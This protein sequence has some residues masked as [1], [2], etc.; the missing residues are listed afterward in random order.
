MKK[1]FLFFI[2]LIFT[3]LSTSAQNQQI[4][5]GKDYLHSNEV[6]LVGEKS[7]SATIQFDLNEL[8]LVEVATNYGSASKMSS[9]KAPI[10][11]DAGN[12]E[13]IYLP[14]ALVIPDVGAAELSITHGAY[15]EIENVEIAPSKGNLPRSVNP[16]TVPYVK[17]AVYEQNAFFPGNL[18]AIN[19]TF[20]M[21]DVR[22]A[23]I[24]AYPVQY[25][26]VTKVL[27]I[28]SEM[29]VT[30][31][32]TDQPGENEF[33]NQ[34]RNTTIDPTFSQMYNNMFINHSS[35]SRDY[36]T[37]EE[38]EL[39]IICYT[40]F[41]DAMKPYIDWK[42]TIGRK[43]TMVSTA[44]IG[45]T[46]AAIKT[47]IANY[48]NNPNNNLAYVLLVGDVAQ[49]PTHS[50]TYSCWPSTCTCYADVEYGKITG[51][52]NYLEVLIGRMSAETLAQVETQVER[53]IW[54]ERDITT[55]DTWL[56]T[57]IGIAAFEGGPP[58]SSQGQSG[59]HD[60]NEADHTH[61]N[62]IRN[63]LLDYGYNPVYQEYAWNAGVPNTNV[64]QISSRFD[65]G[66]G[67]ANYCN[68]GS[69]TA[70]TLSTSNTGYLTYGI[71]NVNALQN[72]GKLPFI[73]S[74]ACNNGEFP[75]GTCF[76]EAWMRATQSNQPTGAVATFMATVSIGWVPP[77]TAQDEF[78]DIC[79]GITHTAG[80]FN[81]GVNGS[82]RTFAGAALNASQRMLQRHGVTSAKEDFNSWTVFGDP[83]LMIRTKVPQEMTISHLP[84][85]S[86][87][88][89]DFAVECDVDGALVAITY[90]DENDEVIIL[91]TAMVADGVAEIVFNEPTVTHTFTLAVTGFDQVTYLSV[92]YGGDI[93]ELF[94]PQNLT[95]T[96]E[97]ASHVLLKWD[98]P[99]EN[100]V[101]P[102]R[103]YNV[104]RNDEL[105]TLEP[106]RN[107]TSFT[108]IVPQ[109]G[110][111]EY[112]VAALYNLS[113]SLESEHSNPVTVLIEG[114]CVP[115][116]NSITVVV[117]SGT[118]VLIS[119]TVPE[120]EGTE[121][122]G[123]N[124]FKDDEQ[125]NLEIIPATAL[126]FL[127]NDSFDPDIWDT[128]YCYHV[129]VVYNDCNENLASEKECL[130]VLSINNPAGS[131]TFNIFPNP[132]V[133]S[134]IIEGAGLNHVEIYNVMGRKEKGEG[135]REKREE[136]ME[137]DVA[138]LAVGVY[139]VRIYSDCNEV[140]VKRLVIV[141]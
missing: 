47:Y 108:D 17:G 97:E 14:T 100:E 109:N 54:Y 64:A 18:A 89:S 62:N 127:H 93:P 61:M 52:D 10:M 121:L 24:F 114:M 3:F 73:F 91:G 12:P 45:S 134:I 4:V 72:A 60:G 22:G 58:G 31:N 86:L 8:N 35:L 77:M 26:P 1:H 34:K 103:G 69:K 111:Y 46:V 119:W 13:L 7:I 132:A 116:S 27:R 67:M 44:E 140:V 124:V 36:P 104:Y 70:W 28:Y 9:A 113:G 43:T 37:G 110:E 80:G 39:L 57:A 83:T 96:V 50:Y 105:I 71:T 136:R 42:H 74:V 16:E 139:F 15:I 82:K 66:A 112:E 106:V 78:I 79:L 81:Y 40:N 75:N 25:N 48:Y 65:A 126:S 29:T 122:A 55:A 125:I 21:R 102:V 94:P 92:I 30:V 87:G 5:V 101:F 129:E 131:Q 88:A 84:T 20:I 41:M 120:Y 38:G 56:N 98:A 117:P 68:H 59:G 23:S 51:G 49:I 90:V 76:A 123:Y 33:I 138:H 130:T 141:K 128:A 118:D 53:S 63:R 115:F 85:I 19:E 95:F 6:T 137:M 99:E 135:R 133:G 32:F 2:A 107:G 11:L